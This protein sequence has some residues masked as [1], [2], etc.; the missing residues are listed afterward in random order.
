[1]N[2]YGV[3]A[4]NIT[5]LFPLDLAGKE[6]VEAGR[7]EITVNKKKKVASLSY[8]NVTAEYHMKHVKCAIK[9]NA[10]FTICIDQTTVFAGCKCFS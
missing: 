7:N 9:V 4:D 2:E 3:T 1:M 8:S 10:T 5:F 6:V